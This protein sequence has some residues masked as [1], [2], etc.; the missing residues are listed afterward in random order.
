VT[1]YVCFVYSRRTGDTVS[2]RKFHLY[3]MVMDHSHL[4][5]LFICDLRSAS[6]LV[7]KMVSDPLH[8]LRLFVLC[9]LRTRQFHN[10]YATY[11]HLIHDRRRRSASEC[12]RRA[13]WSAHVERMGRAHWSALFTLHFILRYALLYALFYFTLSLRTL[14][15]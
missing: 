8:L 10:W 12:M 11:A 15:S 14:Q 5:L 1:F 4:L 13:H 3:K 6:A 7:H 2:R 9:T